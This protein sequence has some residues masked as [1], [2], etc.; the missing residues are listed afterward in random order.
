MKDS[1]YKSNNEWKEKFSNNLA[2]FREKAYIDESLMPKR[3]VLV[4]TNLCNLACDFCFQHRTKQKGAM[5]SDDW[6]K[7]VNDLPKGSRVTLTGGEPLA[8]KNFREIFSE[9]VKNHECN[10]ITNG[11]LLNEDIIDFFL[12][13]KN[14]KV[15]SISIDN[16]KNLIRKLANVKEKK[17]DE[18]W[19]HVEK[20]MLYFQKRKIEL[21]HQGC[22]LDSKTV[23]LDENGEDLYDIHK[24][25]LDDLQC[26][27]HSFQFLKGSPILGCDYMYKF[28]DI[29]EKSSAYKYKNWDKIKEQLYLVKKYN[30]K[31][32]K[33]GFLH[34]KVD[35]LMGND[36]P[37][38]EEKIDILNN[39][40]HN[41]EK[42]LP[43]AQP[44]ASA[45]VNVDGTVFPC[46]AV[47]VGN[48]KDQSIKN[49]MFDKMMKKF[50]NVMKKNGTVEACNRCGWLKLNNQEN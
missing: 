5:N 14:F 12:M 36:E 28:D 9:T 7:L 22:V 20:M 31:N 18:K 38:D 50:K 8:I 24:Y 15:L 11:L 44:W 4:L 26:D 41:K 13:E 10:I 2:E 32:K 42:F 30:Y 37:L 25:C 35:E 29:F 46:L 27:T 21:N 33:V 39:V 17:W 1:D 49:I 48:V 23:V 3:Y 19:E 34:P 43:C 40:Q 45:H 6:I 47:S 16:R